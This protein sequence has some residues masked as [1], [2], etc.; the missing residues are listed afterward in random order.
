M[1]WLLVLLL[2]FVNWPLALAVAAIFMFFEN[3][4]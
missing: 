2:V 4:K 1:H 3:R